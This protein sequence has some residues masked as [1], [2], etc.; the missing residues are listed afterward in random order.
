MK[1]GHAMFARRKKSETRDPALAP[2]VSVIEGEQGTVLFDARRG[3]YYQVNELGLL[4][5]RALGEGLGS[6]AIVERVV[7]AYDV[8]LDVA[9]EDVRNFLLQMKEH[10]V[11]K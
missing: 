7:D 9:A 1:D 5:V 11:V 2:S 10:E 8:S 6:E 3:E 4:I